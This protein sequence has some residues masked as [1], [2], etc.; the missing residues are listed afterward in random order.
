MK[1]KHSGYFTKKWLFPQNDSA[2]KK[3]GIDDIF[4]GKFDEKKDMKLFYGDDVEAVREKLSYIAPENKENIGNKVIKAVK[5]GKIV[6]IKILRLLEKE[7]D[8][9][10]MDLV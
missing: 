2:L 9:E 10:L 4:A 6:N 8:V 7:L 5:Q 3:L 1:N